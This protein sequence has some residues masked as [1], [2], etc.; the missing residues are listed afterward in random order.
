MSNAKTR[1]EVL[2][3]SD[4]LHAALADLQ[5]I[6]EKHGI[7]IWGMISLDPVGAT[8]PPE[9]IACVRLPECAAD[10]TRAPGECAAVALTDTGVGLIR[11]T[12]AL[13]FQANTPMRR[14]TGEPFDP[15][16]GRALPA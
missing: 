11:A 1:K 2:A 3:E 13:D 4:N 9:L 7:C 8:K 5:A 15:P 6:V 12:T 14:D 10:C 16:P